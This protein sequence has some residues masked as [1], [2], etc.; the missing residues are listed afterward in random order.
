M[1]YTAGSVPSRGRL[2]LD[3]LNRNR[4]EYRSMRAYGDVKLATVLFA[5]KLARRTWNTGITTVSSRN[6]W[7][8]HSGQ[9]PGAIQA[10]REGGAVAAVCAVSW[11]AVATS[12]A[13]LATSSPVAAHPRCLVSWLNSS[14][15]DS[16]PHRFDPVRYASS[17]SVSGV[18]ARASTP[19]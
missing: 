8:H 3:D 18:E 13:H 19:S 5:E 11:T 17:T 16:S 12:C 6:P 10:P 4:G 15:A 2:R 14:K 9:R 1:I 7:A